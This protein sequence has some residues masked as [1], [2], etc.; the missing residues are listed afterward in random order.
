MSASARTFCQKLPREL[1][2]RWLFPRV[3]GNTH[4][5]DLGRPSRTRRAAEDS[6]TVRGPVLLSE[7][8]SFSSRYSDQ[9]SARYLRLPAPGEEKQAH[10]R[11]SQMITFTIA[12]ENTA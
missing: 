1:P 2:D 11:C 6:Q 3:D 5:P 9:W 8:W 10:D 12:V 4:G 7:R